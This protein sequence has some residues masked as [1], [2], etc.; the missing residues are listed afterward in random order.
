MRRQ[1]LSEGQF[2]PAVVQ[3]LTE[4]PQQLLILGSGH[5]RRSKVRQHPPQLGGALTRN[6]M[7][8]SKPAAASSST[9]AVSC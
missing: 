3:Y 7:G 4:C 8:R 5:Q 9:A 2:T 6:P 1:C